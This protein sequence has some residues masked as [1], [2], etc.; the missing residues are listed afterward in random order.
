MITNKSRSVPQSLMA[1]ISWM[2]IVAVCVLA[3][4]N[5]SPALQ[6]DGD[7]DSAIRRLDMRLG[8]PLGDLD[9]V[10]EFEA[11]KHIFELSLVDSPGVHVIDSLEEA[12]EALGDGARDAVED[13]VDFES[14]KL[15]IVRYTLGG[16]PMGELQH[17]TSDDGSK[18]TFYVQSPRLAPGTPRGLAAQICMDFFAVP[19]DV[20]VEFGETR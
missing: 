15:V 9:T 18:V 3:I 1:G 19:A 10:E 5:P 13:A 11:Y 12:V 4:P 6:V 16:P 14:E 20:E 2:A 17:E 7:D 8:E